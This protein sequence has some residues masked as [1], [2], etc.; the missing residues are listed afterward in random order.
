MKVAKLAMVGVLCFLARMDLA[1]AQANN[2]LSNLTAPTAINQSLLF[3]G[4]DTFTI[5]NESGELTAIYSAALVGGNTGLTLSAPTAG[6]VMI[7]QII[8]KA[9]GL[10]SSTLTGCGSGA[11][12]VG[13]DQAGRI[14]VGAGVSACTLTFG[15]KWTNA[16]LCFVSNETA[17]LAMKVTPTTSSVMFS[18]IAPFAEATVLDYHC[19]GYE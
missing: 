17:Q 16:P 12:I 8:T 2:S 15:Q 14:H 6:I 5:G 19:V 3:D 1:S 9:A 10:A 7:G 4:N 18:A 11:T 13:N